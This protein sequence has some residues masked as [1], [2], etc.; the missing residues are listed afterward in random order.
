M[1]RYLLSTISLIGSTSSMTERAQKRLIV[2]NRL[3][4]IA[5]CIAVLRTGYIAFFTPS[6]Y[7]Y[8]ALGCSIVFIFFF[9]LMGYMMF[10]RAFRTATITEFFIVPPALCLVNWYTADTGL[11]MFIVLY[12]MF[13]FFYLNKF[14]NVLI[15]FLYC[16]A[17]FIY[18]HFAM[19]KHTV[20]SE[21]DSPNFVLSIFNYIGAFAM[22]FTT[23]Y[24]IKYHVWA[25]EVSIRQKNAELAEHTGAI[26]AQR[27]ELDRQASVLR[28]KTSELME[29]NHVKNKLFSII[30]HDLRTSVYSV[31]NL[32]DALDKGYMTGQEMLEMAPQAN[33][34]INS[35]IDLVNNLLNWARTQFNESKVNP[36]TL[37]LVK[38]TE[39]TF[40][41]FAKEASLKG[42]ELVNNIKIYAFAYADNDMIASVVRNLISN[43][44]KFTHKGS[45]RVEVRT[46]PD[47]A[48]IRLVVNDNGVGMTP[49]VIEQ[50]FNNEY[51]TTPGT[52]NEMGTGLGLM[53]CRDF[54][55]LNNGRIDVRS[56]PGK[57][58]TFIVTLPYNHAAV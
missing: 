44:I 8:T 53:I 17:F 28:E 16:F 2:F 7:S 10:L 26:I 1:Y 46:E 9:L 43:A 30:S 18:M 20:F 19:H 4:F 54:V 48:F 3:N 5:F 41:L 36:K 21:P 12:M 51:Y 50:V 13:C 32:F 45:G 27:D 37:D 58:T 55:R 57:G 52:S 33:R 22:I 56:S 42:I 47:G 23:M 24:L 14:R 15:A 31:K 49:D 38:I 40:R 34:E 39:T 11:D 29:L 25:Y 35:S 6:F